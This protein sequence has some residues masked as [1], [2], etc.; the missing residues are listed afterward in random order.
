MDKSF[1]TG[2]FLVLYLFA[3]AGSISMYISK[4]PTQQQNPEFLFVGF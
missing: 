2:C 1:G 4:T 3:D